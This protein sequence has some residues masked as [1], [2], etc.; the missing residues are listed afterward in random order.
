VTE[1]LP[2]R[3][4]P[5]HAGKQVAEHEPALCPNGQEDQ[6]HLS[7]CWKYRGCSESN[8]CY[9]AIYFRGNYNKQH[10]NAI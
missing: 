3:K 6:W 10:S 4:R 9:S 5:G 1:D 8:A 7:Q 2:V